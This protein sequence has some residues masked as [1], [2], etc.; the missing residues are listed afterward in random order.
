[1]IFNAFPEEYLGSG[2]HGGKSRIYILFSPCLKIFG[3]SQFFPIKPKYFFWATQ[4][5][6]VNGHRDCFR[7]SCTWLVRAGFAW[8]CW[9]NVSRQRVP[10]WNHWNQP[11][12]KQGSETKQ[13]KHKTRRIN[14]RAYTLFT[15][16][17]PKHFFPF[18][19]R[20]IRRLPISQT[21][22]YCCELPNRMTRMD[23]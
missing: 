10:I 18:A 3:P 8:A 17:K 12:C 20:K 13:N 9:K 16:G 21:L 6:I 2:G 22:L 14:V 1:M 5:C 11:A 4:T 23:A 15:I 19:S 7:I